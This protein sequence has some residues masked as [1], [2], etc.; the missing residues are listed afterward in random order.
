MVWKYCRSISPEWKQ[1]VWGWE[2]DIGALARG[3]LKECWPGGPS[4]QLTMCPQMDPSPFG[5]MYEAETGVDF[6][7]QIG[8]IF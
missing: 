7:R 6:A 2:P 8:F 5:F 3:P 4:P 1:Q